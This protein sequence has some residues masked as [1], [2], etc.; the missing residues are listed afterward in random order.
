MRKNKN[1][2][3]ILILLAVIILLVVSAVFY[4]KK[5]TWENTVFEIGECNSENKNDPT[6]EVLWDF[7]VKQMLETK[8]IWDVTVKSGVYYITIY[9]VPEYEQTAKLHGASPEEF[10][11][12][13]LQGYRMK[14]T[15]NMEEVCRVECKKTGE[16]VVDTSS[17]KDGI[18]LVQTYGTSDADIKYVNSFEYK[19]YKWM[20]VESTIVKMLGKDFNGDK[21]MPY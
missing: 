9:W 11:K 3:I 7:Q 19:H 21:Y 18:Y 5:Y 8:L 10:E 6:G 13:Y 4:L 1:I 15:D 14:V 17:W 2:I 20:D 16:Y 12:A